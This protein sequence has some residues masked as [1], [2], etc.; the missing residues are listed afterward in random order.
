M[1]EE[2]VAKNHCTIGEAVAAGQAAGA[3][4]TMLTHFSQRY[5]KVPVLDHAEI[6]VGGWWGGG[7]GRVVVV[8]M[9]VGWGGGGNPP[10]KGGFVGAWGG[11]G[12]PSQEGE[13][14][15]FCVGARR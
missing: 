1:L 11:S 3:F 4:L 9:V 10:R 7:G 2:A 13:I 6:Q 12:M 5:P 15:P 8:V 14:T